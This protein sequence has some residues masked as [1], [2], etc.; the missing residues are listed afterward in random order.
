VQ[1]VS[2]NF[3]EFQAARVV[4]VKINSHPVLPGGW[5][6]VQNSC[7][8]PSARKHQFRVGNTEAKERQCAVSG[9]RFGLGGVGLFHKA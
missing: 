6:N 3:A 4:L 8:K 7:G 2:K 1:E 5:G 9:G